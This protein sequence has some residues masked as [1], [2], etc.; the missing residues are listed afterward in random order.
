LSW[1]HGSPLATKQNSSLFFASSSSSSSSPSHA[2]DRR[3]AAAAAAAVAAAATTHQLPQQEQMAT[4]LVA[5]AS[6][7]RRAHGE[8]SPADPAQ[9]A[10]AQAEAQ[11]EAQ[12]QAHAAHAALPTVSALIRTRTTVQSTS[13]VRLKHHH[14][15]AVAA[16]QNKRNKGNSKSSSRPLLLQQQQQVHRDAAATATAAAASAAD[17]RGG[18]ESTS[19]S[20]SLKSPWQ[21]R[22]LAP[23]DTNQR[24]S[25]IGIGAPQLAAAAAAFARPVRS[26]AAD[27]YA[28]MHILVNPLMAAASGASAALAPTHVGG[29]AVDPDWG[30]LSSFTVPSSSATTNTLS[31]P[32][33]VSA[34]AR[35][36]R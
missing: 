14:Q 27:E 22:A 35:A 11:A 13:H 1:P 24:H 17:G 8:R 31:V 19:S 16:A 26:V 36:A 4:E 5:A 34:P 18:K 10:Q 29:G 2:R 33:R 7:P 21:A 25:G 28:P 23:A 32:F 12:A 20:S 30:G 3:P 6:R 9:A 15:A